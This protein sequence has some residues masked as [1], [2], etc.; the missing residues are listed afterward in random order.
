MAALVVVKIFTT[1]ARD[2]NTNHSTATCCNNMQA[3]GHISASLTGP[4]L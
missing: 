2:E 3:V 1:L 4:P